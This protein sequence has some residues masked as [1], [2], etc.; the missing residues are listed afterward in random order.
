MKLAAT[1]LATLAGVNGEL[2]FFQI[3]FQQF[4]TEA[5]IACATGTQLFEVTCDATNGF[6]IKINEACRQSHF[7]FV[8][9]ANSFVWGDSTKM[10][11]VDASLATAAGIDAAF[12]GADGCTDGTSDYNVKPGASGITDSAGTAAFGW[13]QIPLDS[14]GISSRV[15]TDG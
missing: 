4:F 3:I 7:S 14:C 8:D 13:E 15:E 2:R 1:I 10:S 5:T 12:T 9:F 6:D 11:M